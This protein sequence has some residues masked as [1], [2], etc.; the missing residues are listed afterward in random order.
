VAL[1]AAGGLGPPGRRLAQLVYWTPAL[2]LALGT[3]H[4]PGPAL[5]APAFALYLL[6]RLKGEP[7]G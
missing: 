3:Y 5:I 6:L 4:L 7:A 2:Q 1:L